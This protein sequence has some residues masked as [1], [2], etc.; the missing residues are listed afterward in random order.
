MCVAGLM[1]GMTA[2]AAPN[3]ALSGLFDLTPEKVKSWRAS[4]GGALYWNQLDRVELT[5]RGGP[6]E[7]ALNQH[8]LDLSED[9]VATALAKL[10]YRSP[11][12]ETLPLLSPEEIRRVRMA[13]SAALAVATPTQDVLFVSTGPK[14]ERGYT[15]KLTTAGRAFISGGALNVVVGETGRDVMHEVQTAHGGQLTV[16]FDFAQ[17][18]VAAKG[19]VLLPAAGS[20]AVSVRSDWV[21]VPVATQDRPAATP[22]ATPATSA[23]PKPATAAPSAGIR[24]QEERFE[25]LKRLHEKG[26]ITDAEYEK[27]REE[28]LK[29]L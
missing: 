7:D 22:A 11:R 27:K 1:F 13:L 6:P 16:S 9:D 2:F 3:D 14:T 17:R 25:L 19:V 18:G 10:T 29:T 8:P 24:Q 5:A 20:D 28:L 23:S 26:L 4:P 21:R 15:R 12:G